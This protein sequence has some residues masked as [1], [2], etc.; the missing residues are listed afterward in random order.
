M[1]TDIIL[2]ATGITKHFQRGAETIK[3][4]ND[5]SLEINKGEFVSFVG[6]SGSGKTTLLNILGCL[7]NPTS[8]ELFINESNIFGGRRALSESELTLIRRKSFGYVFQNFYLLPT[9]NVLENVL[10][11]RI[12]YNTA[13]DETDAKNILEE[14][15]LGKRLGHMPHQLSGGEMQRV[16]IARALIN[17]TPVILADEPTGNLDSKKS[18]EVG[19]LLR[20]V[21][22]DDKKTV[23]MVTHDTDLAGVADRV[24]KLSD[25][26]I[27]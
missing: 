4:V 11:P 9:M 6:A 22:K 13:G 18:K 20:K 25:G 19:D 16:A 24:I 21:S 7:D 10:L 1:N 5:I 15:G 27:V 12:F 3:A 14:L 2:K 8:G 17:K 26:K 23:I